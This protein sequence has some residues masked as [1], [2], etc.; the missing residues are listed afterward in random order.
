V[1]SVRTFSAHKTVLLIE[2]DPDIREGMADILR[3]TGRRVVEAEDGQ[4]AFAK[5]SFVGRP[6]LILLDLLMPRM[7]GYAFL[8][9]L[10]ERPDAPEFPVLVL[11]AH[12][13]VDTAEHYPG[14]VGTLRKPFHV[15]TLLSW[16]EALC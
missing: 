11:S 10:R 15:K 16:V 5:L 4:D 12:A 8:E 14:V 9:K 6:C 7:D 1:T 3:D 13:S 2:D